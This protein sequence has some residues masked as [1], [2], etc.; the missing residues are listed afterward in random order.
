L[1]EEI[2]IRIKEALKLHINH[3]NY[4]SYV[5]DTHAIAFDRRSGTLTV[6]APDHFVAD[7]LNKYFTRSLKWAIADAKAS[8]SGA[9]ISAVHFVASPHQLSNPDER[10]HRPR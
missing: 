6:E 7:H 9:R 10:D 1:I 3:S 8:I 2:W 5:Q 4:E